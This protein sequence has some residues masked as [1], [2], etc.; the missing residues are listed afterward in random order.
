MGLREAIACRRLFPPVRCAACPR[1]VVP[2][3]GTRLPASRAL[4]C[5]PTCK[6][7]TSSPPAG[8]V[9]GGATVQYEIELLRLSRRGPDALMSGIAQVGRVWQEPAGAGL[10][11]PSDQ[12][13]AAAGVPASLPGCRRCVSPCSASAVRRRRCDGAHHGLRQHH[14]C[15]VCVSRGARGRG[16]ALRTGVAASADPWLASGGLPP[17]CLPS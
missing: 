2:C 5:R 12:G 13:A 17:M 6:Y 9:P 7:A 3:M 11:A 4:T 14:A 16:V 8:V 10:C 1:G 15:R